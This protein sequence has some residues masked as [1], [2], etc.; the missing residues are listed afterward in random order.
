MAVSKD[1]TNKNID[2]CIID[3]SDNT[4]LETVDVGILNS[5][6]VIA[7]PYKI[8]QKFLKYLLTELGSVLAE[9]QYG[10]E[11]ITQLMSGQIQTEAELKLRFYKEVDFIITY[12]SKSNPNATADETLLNA[13]LENFSIVGDSAIMRIQFTFEDQ[14]TI[15]APVRIS[16]I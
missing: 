8:A 12:I 4:G 14:S 13:N 15:L 11:F 10:T 2:L 9:P 5:G 3:T 6:S 7:G 1:Y 16:T